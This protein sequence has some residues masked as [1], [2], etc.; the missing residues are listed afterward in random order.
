MLL[1]KNN[2]YGM[3]SIHAGL[4]NTAVASYKLEWE[5]VKMNERI[6]EML[7]EIEDLLCPSMNFANYRKTL[8]HLE[9]KISPCIPYFPIH[10]RDVVSF[11]ETMDLNPCLSKDVLNQILELGKKINQVSYFFYLFSSYFYLFLFYFYLFLFLFYLFL[12]YFYFLFHIFYFIFLLFFLF[13]FI[14]YIHFFINYNN[15]QKIKFL[16]FKYYKY[17]ILTKEKIL[18][19]ISELKHYTKEQLLRISRISDPEI[20][21][22]MVEN[23]DFKEISSQMNSERP[24][25][26]NNPSF[27]SQKTNSFYIYQ[28]NENEKVFYLENDFCNLSPFK[29]KISQKFFSMVSSLNGVKFIGYNKIIQFLISHDYLIENS[30][31]SI[32]NYLVKKKY[33]FIYFLFLF[34]FLF[35]YFYLFIKYLENSRKQF[36]WDKS[37]QKLFFNW[38]NSRF[39]KK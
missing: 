20:K 17:Q 24:S 25:S 38:N 30:F 1:Q 18:N 2:F 23:L 19:E 3:G 15:F 12:F 26:S 31:K 14:F 36:H 16:Q 29:K 5:K 34:L 9:D 13:Y 35:I 33:F 37:S 10:L 11:S 39:S 32:M 21:K 7:I 8:S 27:L 28:K 22:K 6:N 4:N